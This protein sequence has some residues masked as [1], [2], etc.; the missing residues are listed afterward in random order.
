MQK[1]A[2][3]TVRT[4]QIR[5]EKRQSI[6]TLRDGQSVQKCQEFW[7]SQK[8]SSD[9]RKL[10]LM[11][12]ATG[13]EDQELPLMQWT[14]SLVTS[15]GNCSPNKCF[16]VHVTDISTS[17]VQRRLCESGLH[18]W[19]AA[20]KPLLKDTNNKRHT[21]AKKHEQ[22]T[23]DQSKSVLWSDE[24]KFEIFGSNRRVFV[25]HRVGERMI[26]ACVVPTMKHG[27]GGVMMWG[28]CSHDVV[29]LSDL[30]RIQGTLNQHGYHRI[31]QR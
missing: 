22:W 14:S 4:A 7:K 21:W 11:R 13:M 24:S 19:I 30:F 9:M 31:L 18:G 23:L 27:G 28:C 2:H 29:P 3:I 10:T 6:I 1:I 8:P 17:T 26:S 5:K 16:R 12:T 15:L 25:R 20:K